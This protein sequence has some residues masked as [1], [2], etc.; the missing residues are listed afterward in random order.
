VGFTLPFTHLVRQAVSVL[1]VLT[2][3]EG[4]GRFV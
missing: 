4:S 3:S 2:V 1:K